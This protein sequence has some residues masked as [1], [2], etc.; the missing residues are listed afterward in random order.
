MSTVNPQQG[1]ETV[2]L[3][4]VNPAVTLGWFCREDRELRSDELRYRNAGH[5]RL[6]L[7]TQGTGSNASPD[8]KS[9]NLRARWPLILWPGRQEDYT[10]QIK[11]RTKVAAN[12][13]ARVEG[14]AA[15]GKAG[16][17]SKE[18][19]KVEVGKGRAV[20]ALKAVSATKSK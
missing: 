7:T 1:P 8:G 10:C 16:V 5:V 20:R 6:G 15:R 4:L 13:V 18:A 17:R 2:V 11:I 12:A 3:D 19:V 14:R 9:C